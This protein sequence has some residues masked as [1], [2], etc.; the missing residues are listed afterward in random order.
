VV[1]VTVTG[2]A[3]VVVTVVVTGGVMVVVT[4]VE[5]THCPSIST[6]PAPQ[7][8]GSAA[9]GVPLELEAIAPAKPSPT[10]VKATVLVATPPIVDVVAALPEASCCA[11]ALVANKARVKKEPINIFFMARPFN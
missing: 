3:T 1:T 9:S 5:G 8:M 4:V 7:L 10:A 6:S 2:G 11:E